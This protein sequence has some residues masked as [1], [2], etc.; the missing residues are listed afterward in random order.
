MSTD[1]RGNYKIRVSFDLYS[2]K[3][4]HKQARDIAYIFDEEMASTFKK[5]KAIAEKKGLRVDNVRWGE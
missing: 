3:I 1:Y 2:S 5:V 4:D